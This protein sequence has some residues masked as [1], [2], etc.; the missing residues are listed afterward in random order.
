MALAHNSG[1]Q[2][3]HRDEM[4]GLI[5]V[6]SWVAKHIGFI[7][8]TVATD[9][10]Q[11]LGRNRAETRKLYNISL[12]S[13]FH[14]AKNVWCKIINKLCAT[15]FQCHEWQVAQDS[16]WKWTY[17]HILR[18]SGDDVQNPTLGATVSSIRFKY[19]VEQHSQTRDAW[20]ENSVAVEFPKSWRTIKKLR[21]H[22]N[23]VFVSQNHVMRLT[24][25]I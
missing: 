14:L 24:F 2:D 6:T 15:L 13:S 7:V 3:T 18:M 9:A 1:P 21:L 17:I 8:S 23:F 22:Y 19:T 10:I 25:K 5:P 4:W 16:H 20:Y 12:K 11:R